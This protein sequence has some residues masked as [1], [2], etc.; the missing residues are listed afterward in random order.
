MNL[1]IAAGGT[2]GHIYPALCI[3][4]EAQE[5]GHT[6]VWLGSVKRLDKALFDTTLAKRYNIDLTGIRGNLFECLVRLPYKMIKA[7]I[8]CHFI[9]KHHQIDMVLCMG[10]YVSGPVGILASLYGIPLMLHEANAVPGL[11]TR[12]LTPF[13]KQVLYGLKKKHSEKKGRLT[14]NPLRPDLKQTHHRTPNAWSKQRPFRLLV[15]GGSQG[16]QA[17]NETIL[18]LLHGPLAPHHQHLSVKLQT[19]DKHLKKLHKETEELPKTLITTMSFIE[20]M[21]QAY[22]WADCVI[23]RAGALTVSELALVGCPSLLIPYPH[24]AD[25]HQWHNAQWLKHEQHALCLAQDD[26]LLAKLSRQLI[27]FINNPKALKV[28]QRNKVTACHH[29]NATQTVVSCCEEQYGLQDIVT[30]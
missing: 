18:K 25:N 4:K 22:S 1:L 21:N 8:R 28:M 9:F 29:Q 27:I 30:S 14:G 23:A 10:S 24:A 13:A 16:A 2:G 15:I 3:A 6:I 17:V 19:G 5:R 26:T 20:D 11:T 7:L 12:C